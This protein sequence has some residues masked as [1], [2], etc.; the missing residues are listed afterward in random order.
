MDHLI[1]LYVNSTPH[2]IFSST[3]LYTLFHTYSACVRN[4]F[5]RKREGRKIIK[6]N[7]V[8]GIRGKLK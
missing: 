7:L 1:K 4:L 2:L 6:E 8:D 3:T 5:R